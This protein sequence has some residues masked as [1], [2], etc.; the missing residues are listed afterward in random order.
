[1]N[2]RFLSGDELEEFKKNFKIECVFAPTVFLSP[3]DNQKYAIGIGGDG[4]IPIPH[5]MTQQDVH[6]R[7]LRKNY[8]KTTPKI[9]KK[10]TSGRGKGEY[11][12]QFD[13]TWNCTCSGFKFRGS[14]AHINKV[15]TEL[16]IKFQ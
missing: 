13:K 14:C 6:E 16:K 15:K 4:W 2:I 9:S 12:V 1:M 11:T 8:Q 10:I 5:A 3:T 7:W